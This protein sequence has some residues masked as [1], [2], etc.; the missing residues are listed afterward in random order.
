MDNVKRGEDGTQ[1]I[2]WNDG[3]LYITFARTT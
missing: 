1:L 3:D 2:F